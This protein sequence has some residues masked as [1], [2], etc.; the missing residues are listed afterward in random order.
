MKD[1]RHKAADAIAGRVPAGFHLVGEAPPRSAAKEGRIR[2]QCIADIEREEVTWLWRGRVPFGKVTLLDGDPGL[3][4]SLLSCVLAAAVTRGKPL[5]GDTATATRE[6]ASVIM[7]SA[8]DDAGDTVRARLEAA[9][10]DLLRV[11]VLHVDAEHAPAIPGD[12]AE[13]GRLVTEKHAALVV[14]DPLM[15]FLP[16][17]I[18]AHKD[19]H[20]RRAM[21]ALG[22]MA[23][24]THAAVLIVRHLN[25]TAGASA[26]Y[27]GGGS[28]G[29]AGAARSVLLV[30]KDSKDEGLCHL[31]PIKSNLG[32]RAPTL[33]YRVVAPDGV[34]VIKW[35]AGEG[36]LG[37]DE[38]LAIEPPRQGERRRDAAQVL[39]HE[40]A[41]GPRSGREVEAAATAAGIAASTLRR[42]ADELGVV[43]RPGGYQEPWQWELPPTPVGHPGKVAN[44]VGSP[45]DPLLGGEL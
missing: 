13:L 33:G 41:G 25:K 40:L 32:P 44:A 36:G 45:A 24:S 14:F 43:R 2:L 18:D 27:R 9:D 8:E 28:I 31:A 1:L 7:F 22:R 12:V 34:P 20:V 23:A 17:E 29:I 21:A 4:K 37:A 10:A 39:R 6:P 26:L 5:C 42:A 30:A 15:A 38:L 16:S 35:Q 11:H 3:G 19:Q